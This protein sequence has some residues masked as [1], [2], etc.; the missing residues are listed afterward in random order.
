MSS[1]LRPWETGGT[2]RFVDAVVFPQAAK[3]GQAR[4]LAAWGATAH[5]QAPS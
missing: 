3:Q 2:A 1:A 5:A 4:Q